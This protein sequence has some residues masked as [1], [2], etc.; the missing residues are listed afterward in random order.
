MKVDIKLFKVAWSCYGNMRQTSLFDY[1]G[2]PNYQGSKDEIVR[3]S[4]EAEFERMI[5]LD[6]C[7]Q[8]EPAEMFRSC[9]EYFVKCPVCGKRTKMYGHMYKAKQAWNS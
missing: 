8:T 4:I 5:S 2:D 9:H 1:S 6:D 3:Y 7:C